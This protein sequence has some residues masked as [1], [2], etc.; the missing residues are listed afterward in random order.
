MLLVFSEHETVLSS[1]QTLESL[2]CPIR[3]SL[4]MILSIMGHFQALD[5]AVVQYM[6]VHAYI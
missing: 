2:L 4:L 6:K 1:N 5:L 3:A